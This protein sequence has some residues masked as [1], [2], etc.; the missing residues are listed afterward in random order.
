MLPEK[1][2]CYDNSFLIDVEAIPNTT[3]VWISTKEGLKIKH[4]GYGKRRTAEEEEGI[5][6]RVIAI[7]KAS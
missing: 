7:V 1:R 4:R 3:S 2:N 6:C 5:A